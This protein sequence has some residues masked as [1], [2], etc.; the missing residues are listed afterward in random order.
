MIQCLAEGGSL[1][2][3]L[4]GWNLRPLEQVQFE[5]WSAPSRR[6][7]CGGVEHLVEHLSD[8]RIIKLQSRV[9]N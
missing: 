1:P 7:D 4:F 2:A 6:R 8:A 9:M 3:A 5:P